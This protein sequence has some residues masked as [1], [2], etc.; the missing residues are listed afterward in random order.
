VRL[1]RPLLPIATR[2]ALL[3][4]LASP[5]LAQYGRPVSDKEEHG[6]WRLGFLRLTPLVQLRNAGVDTNPF[7]T[8]TA[9]TEETEVVLRA[10][11]Q[12]CVPVGRRLRLR[13]DG[14]LDYTFYSDALQPRAWH[15]GGDARAELAL[16]PFTFFGGGGEFRARERYT[17]DIDTRVERREGWLNGGVQYQLTRIF[18]VDVGA[19]QRRYRYLPETVGAAPIRLFLDRDSLSYQGRLRHALTPLTT[20][21][22]SAEVT[23][24]TFRFAEPS[25]ATTRSYLYLG[26][27]ELADKALVR[28]RLLAGVRD[29]PARSAGSVAAY[30][31]P[32]VQSALILPLLQQRLQLSASFNRDAYYS[33]SASDGEAETLRNIYTYGRWGFAV[34]FELPLG[35]I[36]RAIAGWERAEYQLPS[37]VGDT[38]TRREDRIESLGGSLLRRLGRNARLGLTAVHTKRTSS[39]PGLAYSRWQ[40]GLQGE[41]TP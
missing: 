36:G 32:A 10:G 8:S 18:G 33:A 17:T 6:L 35:L 26:G 27:F 34:E 3:L 41:F 14:W 31:G 30:R 39:L 28:G 29:I 23:D 4:C 12:V 9:A 21:L 1:C 11:L 15:P 40:Y 7:L 5:A 37:A 25:R 16:G 2:A 13:G 19:E 20:A 38:L 22:L 24:D